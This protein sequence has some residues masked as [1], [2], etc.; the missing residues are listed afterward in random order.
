M[1]KLDYA[2]AASRDRMRGQGVE[3]IGGS[4]H[5]GLAPPKKRK[6][7]AQRRAEIVAATALVTRLVSCVCGH[8]ACVALPPAKLGRRLRCSRCGTFAEVQA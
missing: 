6:T 2:R 7:K 1:A 4:M 8:S 5:A 3:A